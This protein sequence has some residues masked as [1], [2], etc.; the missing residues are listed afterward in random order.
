MIHSAVKL[1]KYLHINCG[2]LLHTIWLYVYRNVK[3]HPWIKSARPPCKH[4]LIQTGFSQVTV[5]I[6]IIYLWETCKCR[7][8][9]WQTV[10]IIVQQLASIWVNNMLNKKDMLYC[11][12]H[13]YIGSSSVSVQMCAVFA[14][15][16]FFSVLWCFGALFIC[17]CFWCDADHIPHPGEFIRSDNGMREKKNAISS[18]CY[19]KKKCWKEIHVEI[20]LCATPQISFNSFNF[21]WTENERKRAPFFCCCLTVVR[22][23]W[24]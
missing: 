1:N 21:T 13:E 3:R 18:F 14:L 6:P 20:L 2:P 9:W 8:I 7:R 12:M 5:N 4:T 17:R 19:V 22:T 10:F 11:F 24:M 23:L 16:L 15:S